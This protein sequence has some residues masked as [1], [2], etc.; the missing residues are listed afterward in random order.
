VGFCRWFNG[1]NFNVHHKGPLDLWRFSRVEGLKR[2]AAD[3]SQ[4]QPHL[5]TLAVA[6]CSTT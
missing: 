6:E 3:T 4:R 5:V 1:F 2:E